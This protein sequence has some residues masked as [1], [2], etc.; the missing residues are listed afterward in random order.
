MAEYERDWDG[1]FLHRKIKNEG[2]KKAGL[3]PL[4]RLIVHHKNRDPSDNRPPNL[5]TMTPEAHYEFH[6][7]SKAHSTFIRKFKENHPSA[8]WKTAS[9]RWAKFKEKHNI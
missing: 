8:S 6:K 3:P 4:G 9:Y 1:Q 2:R 7:K 5:Q